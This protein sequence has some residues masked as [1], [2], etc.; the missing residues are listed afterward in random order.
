MQQQTYEQAI[1]ELQQ[2]LKDLQNGNVKVDLLSE[3]ANRAAELIQ[4]CKSKLRH[5]ET[6]IQHLFQELPTEQND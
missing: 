2:I 3:K 6:H 1:E 4:I 5:V